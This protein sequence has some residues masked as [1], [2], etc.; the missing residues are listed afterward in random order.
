[1][2]S[3]MTDDELDLLGRVVD[4]LDW[5]GKGL[6]LEGEDLQTGQ[7]LSSLGYID[8][9]MDDSAVPTDKGSEYEDEH[10]MPYPVLEDLPVSDPIEVSDLNTPMVGETRLSDDEHDFLARAVDAYA[11]NYVGMDFEVEDLELAERLEELGLIHILEGPIAMPTEDGEDAVS[12]RNLDQWRASASGY[13]AEPRAK[14]WYRKLSG[15]QFELLRA[16]L[17]SRNGLDVEEPSTETA[18][19]LAHWGYL[20]GGVGRKFRIA[21]A[22]RQY[23]QAVQA[24]KIRLRGASGSAGLV[25]EKLMSEIER[26]G[27]MPRSELYGMV[28]R[29]REVLGLRL[30]ANVEKHHPLVRQAYPGLP[31]S[32]LLEE[33]MA[34]RGGAETAPRLVKAGLAESVDG[35]LGLTERPMRWHIT[36]A[37]N[38]R[39]SGVD[40]A[41]GPT[42]ALR[43]FGTF[44]RDVGYPNVT[45][46]HLR[47]FDLGKPDTPRNP[48]KLKAAIEALREA[49]RRPETEIARAWVELSDAGQDIDSVALSSVT[50]QI[51]RQL[52]WDGGQATTSGA[53]LGVSVEHWQENADTLLRDDFDEPGAWAQLVLGILP[54]HPR[55]VSW[56]LELAE[57]LGAGVVMDLLQDMQR[58]GYVNRRLKN[59]WCITPQGEEAIEGQLRIDP[60]AVW[61]GR[62]ELAVDDVS[63]VLQSELERRIGDVG[64][65]WRFD[66]TMR[67][68][69]VSYVLRYL[70]ERH[71]PHGCEL[72]Y[73]LWSRAA[74]GRVCLTQK[75]VAYLRSAISAENGVDWKRDVGETLDELGLIKIVDDRALPLGAGRVAVESYEGA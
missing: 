71:L 24:G 46:K 5:S 12:R 40:V 34:V 21:E 42:P 63:P 1:M 57:P 14:L 59:E 4:E 15:A 26:T 65:D 29:Q 11:D 13:A 10:R 16:V 37:G 69:F 50:R 31:E 44:L 58:R 54:A 73:A 20:H 9:L 6:R 39:V 68:G 3:A 17:H 70:K 41:S 67:A 47:A 33:V 61:A 53:Y 62:Q 66:D 48:I 55:V 19:K 25:L 64:G 28:L 18:K 36:Q 51:I 23:H 56:T 2:D 52:A 72:A 38:L 35:V 45:A 32:E 75:E 74:S 22:G 49:H 30:Q 7:R 27:T 43:R 8:I 60:I